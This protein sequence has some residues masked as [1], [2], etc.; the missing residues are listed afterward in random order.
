MNT[1]SKIVRY[2]SAAL[3]AR[4]A[5]GKT[6]TDWA[7][8]D[9]ASADQVDDSDMPENFWE[10]ANLTTVRRKIQISFRM[11]TELLQWLKQQAKQS[12]AKGY[13]SLMHTILTSYRQKHEA[14]TQP[15]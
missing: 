10:N 13:Q 8:V 12:N 4:S 2:T 9:A 3:R 1:E 15:R 7:K 6:Q 14:K 11:D 5:A